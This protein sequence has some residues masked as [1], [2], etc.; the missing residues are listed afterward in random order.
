LA[1]FPNLAGMHGCYSEARQ[2]KQDK[3]AGDQE[4]TMTPM[5]L[6]RMPDVRAAARRLAGALPRR[7]A[8]AL[9]PAMR[10]A[11]LALCLPALLVLTTT[12]CDRNKPGPKPIS[13]AQAP[14]SAPAAGR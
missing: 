10:G 2:G 9:A 4:R 6:H 5:L 12:G 11:L 8:G 13:G 3:A 7:T 14:A 1:R